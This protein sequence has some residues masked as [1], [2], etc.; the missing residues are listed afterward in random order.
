M[1][2]IQLQWGAKDKDL[3]T[4]ARGSD[5]C[6]G[7]CSWL[8]QLVVASWPEVQNRSDPTK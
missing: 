5:F 8:P 7:C 2:I 6:G 4:G 3:Q 1:R